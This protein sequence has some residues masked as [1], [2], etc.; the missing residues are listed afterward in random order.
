MYGGCGQRHHNF[1]S[2]ATRS[3]V[4]CKCMVVANNVIT[5]HTLAALGR[6]LTGCGVSKPLL[7]ETKNVTAAVVAAPADEVVGVVV[8][9][10]V[11]AVNIKC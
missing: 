4:V 9:V 5:S 11:V 1:I 3:R 2:Q 6:E 7:A 8:V 10:V